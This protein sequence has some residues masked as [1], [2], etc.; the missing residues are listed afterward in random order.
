MRTLACRLLDLSKVIL[1]CPKAAPAARVW[2]QRICGYAEE[3]SRG[4]DPWKLRSLQRKCHAIKGQLKYFRAFSRNTHSMRRAKKPW[5]VLAFVHMQPASE[6]ISSSE[7]RRNNCLRILR[8]RRALQISLY[9]NQKG[10]KP[11]DSRHSC[12]CVVAIAYKEATDHTI[13]SWNMLGQPHALAKTMFFTA[14]PVPSRTSR[15]TSKQATLDQCLH[16]AWLREAHARLMSDPCP[17]GPNRLPTST[18]SGTLWW[19]WCFQTRSCDHCKHQSLIL[20][21]HSIVPLPTA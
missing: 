12:C 14:S 18:L 7:E 13:A 19:L 5:Y 2:T 9:S 11:E 8:W 1:Q 17:C 3:W 16:V 6:W 15:A 4:T 21:W 10:L 20:A